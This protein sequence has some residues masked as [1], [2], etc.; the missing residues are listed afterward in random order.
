MSRVS[1][2]AVVLVLVV[3]RNG[4]AD[5]AADAQPAAVVQQ[6]SEPDQA[7]AEDAEGQAGLPAALPEVRQEHILYL[8]FDK[9]SEVFGREDSSILLPYSKYLEMWNR[10]TRPEPLPSE[11]P[12]E[13]VIARAD[14]QGSVRGDLVHLQASLAVQV[15]GEGWA[16]VPLTFGDAAVGSAVN[17]DGKVLL[18]GIGQGGYELLLHG[19]GR[20]AVQLNLVS[21]VQTAAEGRSFTLQCPV[22]GV[23]NLELEIP[24]PDLA[25][26]VA[27]RRTF[28]MRADR[29][30]ATAVRAVLGA[31]DRFTVRW[32]PASDVADLA[33]GLANVSST[34]AVDV[35]DGVV[36][37][38]AEFDYQILR[39]ALDELLIDVPA[40]QRLLDVQ[41]AGLRDWQ[42]EAVEDRQHVRVRLH[43]PVTGSVRL[44]LHTEAPLSDEAFD[45]GQLRAIG[46]A[47][48]SGL[49]AVRSAEDVGLEFLARQSLARVDAAEVPEP[50]RRPRSTYFKFFTPDHQLTLA[51]SARQPRI[52]V[53]SR[54][55][56]LLERAKLTTHSEF[57]YQI[58]RS[59]I[60]AL[61]FRLP[62]G[63]QVDD[64]RAEPLE[65]FEIAA[66]EDSQTLNVYFS[67]QVLGDVTVSIT[68]SQT[69]DQ[70]AGSLELPLPEPWDVLREEGLV[71]VIAP[72]SL[73]VTTDA[74]PLLA[75]RTATPAELSS[76]GFQPQTSAGSVL[77]SAFAFVRRP[78]R[79]VQTITERPRRMLATVGTTARLGEDVVQ[80]TSLLQLQV[81]FAGTDTFR[82]AVPD[83]VSDRLQ[84]EGDSIRERRRAQQPDQDGWTEWTIVLHSEALG[85]IALTATYDQPL[86]L[87]NGLAQF[88]LRPIRVLGAD[89]EMGEITIQKD[90]VLSVEATPT[91]LEE[92]DPRELSLPPATGPPYLAYRYYRH[93][94]ELALRMTRHEVQDVVRTVVRRAYVE[95]VV[96]RDGP[97]TMRARYELTSSERQR[98][99][100]TLRSPRILSMT[101]AGQTV[102]PEIAPA[103]MGDEPADRTYFINV[104]RAGETDEPFEIAAIFETPGP[105]GGLNVTDALRLALPRFDHEVRFQR[106]YVRVWMPREYRLVGDPDGFTSHIGVGLWDSRAITPAADDPDTWFPPDSSP[107]DA[108]GTP[109]LFSSLEG[110]AHLAT[111]YWHIP[112]MTFIASAVALALGVVLLRFSL[113]TKVFVVLAVAL[114]G[115]FFGLFWPSVINSWLLAGRLGIA[116]VI[117][118]WL[119]AW[120][121]YVHRTGVLQQMLAAPGVVE[122]PKGG[123]VQSQGGSHAQP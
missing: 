70:P 39:G 103:E 47:R 72:E 16:R 11:P 85:E 117:A 52:V 106:T 120:F 80:V 92:I 122:S 24:E 95:A 109:Y 17:Q 50:L 104:A 55:V 37:T 96:T 23:S 46:V 21:A 13:A 53:D 49:L 57:R 4:F 60:F 7:D 83:V 102:L 89:R 86:S 76:R 5:D 105:T 112:T 67:R 65:R 35:G 111:A 98:L 118:L 33:A 93:P 121:L 12:V 2:L 87:Q 30:D 116:A 88:S 10:L 110:P 66:G 54:F 3:G 82:L 123:Q 42:A 44:E 69:R 9:L 38:H 15:L 97:V 114:T 91:G 74:E 56:V 64:V 90:R 62:L 36:R 41:A 31:T 6:E 58:S 94:A 34:I 18:R 84:I 14:Y 79:I 51:A 115:V 8:P 22:V 108:D 61:S 100:L 40:D 73:E 20:H 29:E 77:A 45:V 1:G 25:V 107:F 26:H 113:E 71:A 48:E 32:H 119:V 59:G 78:V 43:A 27:P 28:E 19:Q 99:A 81:R 75:A 63:I 101:V 68:A